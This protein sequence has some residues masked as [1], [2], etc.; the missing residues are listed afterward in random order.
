MI[1]TVGALGLLSDQ[2]GRRTVFIIA[3]TCSLGQVRGTH[4]SQEPHSSG[5]TITNT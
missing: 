4:A 3:T 5:G 1:V 2:V